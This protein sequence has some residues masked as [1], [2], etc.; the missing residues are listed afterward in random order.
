MKKVYLLLAFV[1]VWILA[2]CGSGSQPLTITVTAASATLQA[3]GTVQATATVANDSANKGVTWT[4]T[5]STAQCGSVSP[6]TTASG[7]ATT[8]TAPSTPPASDLTVTIT[9]T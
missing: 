4:V 1:C 6:A 5:C 8:Y 7:T 2:G 9:T 3:G